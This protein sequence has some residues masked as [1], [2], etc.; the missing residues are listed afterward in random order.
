M[1]LTSLLRQVDVRE[2]F[3]TE[4]EKPCLELKQEITA[5][6]THPSRAHAALVGTAFD[7]VLRLHVSILN[8]ACVWSRDWTAEIAVERL[9]DHI[10]ARI[11]VFPPGASQSYRGVLSKAHR[12][13]GDA[14]REYDRCH[15]EQKVSDAM[16]RFALLLGQLEQF[17][18]GGTLSPL[19]GQVTD[20]GI[21]DLRNLLSVAQGVTDPFRASRVCILNPGFREAS[22]LVGGADAD[23][24]VDDTLIEIKT[25]KDLKFTAE[26]FRQLVGYYTLYKIGGGV[27]I[28]PRPKPE[29][30]SLGIYF[31]RYGVSRSFPVKNV[32]DATRLPDFMRWFKRRARNGPPALRTE[33]VDGVT[34]DC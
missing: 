2:R 11:P 8:E 23:L 34:F 3:N 22:V 32:I 14:R 30:R 10:A 26:T 7:Y 1:S 33:T 27:T 4:F 31:A 13:V 29:I 24:L 20:A 6:P 18:R 25:T 12:I 19:F 21:A 15:D 5:V 17:Y 16:L 28:G 9:A